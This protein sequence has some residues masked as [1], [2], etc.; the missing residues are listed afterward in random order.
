LYTFYVNS[1]DG[2]RLWVNDILL[3]NKWIP[4]ASTEWSGTIS[5]D[6]A[7]KYK[8]RV[9]YFEL[10]G[11]V[12]AKLLWSSLRTPK[13]P[14]PQSQLYVTP[15]T[16]IEPHIQSEYSLYPQPAS[17]TLF[18]AIPPGAILT[19]RKYVIFDSVGKLVAIEHLDDSNSAIDVRQ[20]SPGIYFLRMGNWATKF[21]KR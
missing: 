15:I 4:Q 14:I 7:T 10:A 13:Q 1:D 5:L 20:L 9:E 16:A 2:I 18:I 6:A 21:S 19:D 11:Q 17:E 12:V 3:V 8:I